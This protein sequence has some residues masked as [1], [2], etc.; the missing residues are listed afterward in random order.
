MRGCIPQARAYHTAT[1][2]GDRL[3]VFGGTNKNY[4]SWQCVNYVDYMDVGKRYLVTKHIFYLKQS[5]LK[6]TKGH[7]KFC[8]WVILT[9]DSTIIQE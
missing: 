2:K 1:V 5:K 3:Y 8:S 7:F 4:G 6:I 9:G